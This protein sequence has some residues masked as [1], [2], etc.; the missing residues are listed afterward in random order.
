[1]RNVSSNVEKAGAAW[2]PQARE[3]LVHH[4]VEMHCKV[5]SRIVLTT[6]DGGKIADFNERSESGTISCFGSGATLGG[7]E[8]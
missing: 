6:L 3:V 4:Q 5:C 8:P 2:R 1:M 7:D